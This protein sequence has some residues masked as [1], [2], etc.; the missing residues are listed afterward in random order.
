MKET[1]IH[2]P[3]F[4][5]EK[6]YEGTEKIIVQDKYLN[7][8]LATIS[9]GTETEVNLAVQAAREAFNTTKLTPAKRAELLY[10]AAELFKER[11][12][13]LA[14]TITMEAGKVITDARAEVDRGIQ[15]FIAAAEEGKRITGHTVPVDGQSGNENR[16]AFTIRKPVGVIAA[17]T[18]FNF[19]F[20]LTAHKV[21]PALAS[22]N[23][24][25][26]K[27]SE[28][29]PVSAMKM[30]EILLEAGFPPGYINVVNGYGHETGSHLLKHSGVNMYTFT[31]SPDIGKLIKNN[32]GIRKVTL[33]LGSNAP[34]I[35]HHDAEN[36]KSIAESCVEKGMMN[37]GQACIS[38]QRVYVHDSVADIFLEEAKAAAEAMI[39]GNP[40][41]AD[42]QVG[43]MIDKRSTE[44]IESWVNEAVMEGAE[45]VAGGRRKGSIYFPTILTAVKSSMKVVCEEVF[46]PVIVVES[47]NNFEEAI[48]EANQSR[49]GL[50]AGVFTSNIHLAMDAAAQLEFGGVIINDVSTFRADVM[51]YG[52]IK[53]SGIGKEGP[54]YAIEEMTDEKLIVLKT[55]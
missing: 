47:Y 41:E 50:Q 25:V 10:T 46:A 13:E 28:K 31:G 5:G 38:V 22:G 26:I 39:V 34:N 29:T 49:F 23:T 1:L 9:N 8:A 42:T 51:P 43:P 48:K 15:T 36:I 45:I 27:P 32:T 12:E 18:P 2:Y 53:D 24:L 16:I 44:R 35:V 11:K 37:N 52:G 20:N 30:A 14:E 40:L 55:H 19:P 3:H 33:E 7:S 17:I 54:K 4:I 21:A 6:Q